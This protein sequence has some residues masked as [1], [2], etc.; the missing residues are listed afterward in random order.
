MSTQ[1]PEPEVPVRRVDRILAFSALGLVA[2]SIVCF[3]VIIIGTA[4]GMEQ[5]D[6]AEGAWPLVAGF[7]YWGLLVAFVLII[8][9]L[10]SSFVR[11]SRASRR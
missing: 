2:V 9:L 1:S 10:V 8:S 3:F 6:F 7:P 11:K 4:V 5:D